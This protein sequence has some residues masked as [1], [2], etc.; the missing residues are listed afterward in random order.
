MSVG[1]RANMACA[2]AWFS[3]RLVN[4]EEY[5]YIPGY[6]TSF[7]PPGCE[8]LHRANSEQ[9]DQKADSTLLL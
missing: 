6:L 7:T 1:C 4:Q 8:S 3:L 9:A 2:L 5:K